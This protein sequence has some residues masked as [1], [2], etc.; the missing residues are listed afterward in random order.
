MCFMIKG[1]KWVVFILGLTFLLCYL[2]NDLGDGLVDKGSTYECGFVGL[3][4]MCFY[5]MQ[6][7][8]IGLSFMLFDVEIIVL[9]PLLFSLGFGFWSVFWGGVFLVVITLL[10]VYEMN[11]GVVSWIR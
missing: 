2:G 4:D 5:T 7:F 8:V 9:V 11:K 1:L 6:F 3:V 10:L